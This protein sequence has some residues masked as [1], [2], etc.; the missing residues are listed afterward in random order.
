MNYESGD[1]P[2]SLQRLTFEDWLLKS[3]RRA[4]KVGNAKTIKISSSVIVLLMSI[5]YIL[6]SLNLH[7]TH[8]CNQST[9]DFLYME[10]MTVSYYDYPNGYETRVSLANMVPA[11]PNGNPMKP[12]K[13]SDCR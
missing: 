13:K 10:S 5:N 11:G 3:K 9:F 8:Q 12:C 4:C 6:D 2:H 1:S 7:A